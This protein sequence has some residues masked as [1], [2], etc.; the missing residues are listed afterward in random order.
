MN[1]VSCALVSQLHLHSFLFIT[2]PLLPTPNPLRMDTGTTTRSL[3]I[4]WNYPRKLETSV[5]QKTR[6]VSQSVVQSLLG[7]VS[8][9]TLTQ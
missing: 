3:I 5:N 6:S 7:S 1:N 2:N 8:Y 4:D 9:H